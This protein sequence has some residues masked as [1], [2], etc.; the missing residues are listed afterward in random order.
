MRF[1]FTAADD[2]GVLDTLTVVCVE[3]TFPAEDLS[4]TELETS[5][6]VEAPCASNGVVSV[7]SPRFPEVF[8]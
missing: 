6:G 2:G 3:G 8:E 5:E 1:Q 4:L 7:D